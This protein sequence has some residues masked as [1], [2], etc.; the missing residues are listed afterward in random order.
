[1]T[2]LA[3]V[4]TGGRITAAGIRGISPSAVIKGLD[5]TVTTGSTAF[6]NDNALFLAVAGNATY[7]FASF[8]SYDCDLGGGGGTGMNFQWTVPVGAAMRFAITYK[9]QNLSTGTTELAQAGKDTTT[10]DAA[11]TDV[12]GLNA[13]GAIT[14]NGTLV[15]GTAAGTLQFQFAPDTTSGVT[16][17][18]HAQSYVALWRT[19]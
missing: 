8:V 7:L 14:M 12:V 11:E 6:I 15:T 5:Q 19:A 17:T 16:V 1:M 9:K 3:S 10:Y 18:T 4:Y 13:T 2:A